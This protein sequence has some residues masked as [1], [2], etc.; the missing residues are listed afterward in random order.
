MMYTRSPG[1]V[2]VTGLVM[3]LAACSGGGGDPNSVKGTSGDFLVLRTSPPNN[4]K[5]F[6]NEPIQIDFS[7]EVDLSTAD[8]NTVSFA[9]FDLNG[10]ALNEQ[11]AGEFVVARSTGD[12][13]GLNRQLVFSPRFPTNNTFDNGGFRPGR[14][15][16]TQLVGGDARNRSVLRDTRGKALAQ[17]V[18]FRFTTADGTTP[19][20]LF[21][22]TRPGGPRKSS[23]AV[24]P[25]DNDGVSLNKLGLTAVEIRLGFDQPLNPSSENVPVR[26]QADPLKRD[27]TT[28]GRM[29]LEYDDPNGRNTWIPATVDLEKNT[30]QGS[31][32]VLRPVG[33]LPNNAEV[34][35]VVLSTLEDMSGESNVSDASYDPVFAR[36]GTRRDFE[37]QY[38]AIVERF[39]ST[40]AV[41]TSAAFLEP[42][43]VIRDGRIAASFAFEGGDSRLVYEP[44]AREVILN[45]DFTQI[46]PK[47]APPINVAG[48]VFTFKEVTIP[49]GVLVRGAGTK[50]M[51]WLVTGDFTVHGTLSVD[52]GLGARVDTLN[53]ANF[54][55]GGGVGTCGGG[56][57]GKGSP[58]SAGRSENGEPGF[59]PNQKPGGGGEGGKL[60]CTSSCNRGSAGGGGSLSTQGDPYYPLTGTA[61]PQVTG[62]GG[63][64]C[65]AKTLPGGVPGPR[66]FVDSRAENNFWGA[67]IDVF[68]QIRI[69]GEL[70]TPV[71]GAGGGG[72]G[73]RSTSCAIPGGS[74][75][76]SD[77]KGGGGGGGAGVLI[78]KALGRIIIGRNGQITANGGHGGGGEQAGGN[79]EGGGGGAGSG[80]TIVLMAGQGIDI[81]VHGSNPQNKAT[82][83]EA[84]FEFAIAADGG[85]GTQGRFSSPEILGKYPPGN[86]SWN[87]F[88]TGGFGGMGIIQLMVPP[89]DDADQT[90]NRLD[91]NV[92]FFF[93]NSVGVVEEV[94]PARKKA[95]LAWRGWPDAQGVLRDDNGVQINLGRN[96]GD[97]RPSPIM[98]PSPFGAI[99]RARS[100]WIDLGFAVREPVTGT[101][102]P[103]TPRVVV[104][105]AANA[106]KPDFFFDGTSR[107]LADQGYALYSSTGQVE[108]PV[109]HVGGQNRV[110]I[111][112]VSTQASFGG[113]PAYLVELTE[114]RL[115][116]IKD[117]YAQY[118]ARFLNDSGA[119][120]GDLRILGHT[121]RSLFLEASA[122]IPSGAASL[123][124]V[125]KFFEVITGGQ[126]GLGPTFEVGNTQVPVANVRIGFAFHTKPS[127]GFS[128][129]RYPNPTDPTT[130]GKLFEFDLN[131]VAFQKYLNGD[132]LASP[133]V[134]PRRPSFVQWDI[135]FNNRF[136]P[137]A[138]GNN[139]AQPLTADLPLPTID[140]L[141]IP[142]R[143]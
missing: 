96:E 35:V 124:I 28:R 131:S 140:Y 95:L 78:V 82:Y 132:P 123:Q 12:T 69:E 37:P 113:E 54:P 46:V 118:R 126:P 3:L 129:N 89:G 13:S 125:A 40:N 68:R 104:S 80:G 87:N 36:F 41:D 71:G 22:D 50:P 84:D 42:Q 116:S 14:V 134:P 93:I 97:M 56:N 107:Q 130:P 142:Y 27:L 135:L 98:L 9:V 34:R 53:S 60:S 81:F 92:R 30:L 77:N 102:G 7:N 133:P 65:T 52:G 63:K 21:K 137:T 79:N 74:G 8:L 111:R 103:N 88:P 11:P 110:A 121:D 18:S 127:E 43:A 114:A 33:V 26:V 75:F 99:S 19:A 119:T 48:G 91:D 62:E 83:G 73:D 141:V 90:G 86:T 25:S 109:V 20:Q 51:V 39:E 58:N 112:S 70:L 72:G 66:P 122:P 67:G 115:G 57:G 136:H 106:P 128:A 85:V 143:F 10:N 59:G 16:V 38:D 100:R 15:Y 55:T 47:G 23:F 138:A 139:S 105:S 44:N 2:S 64:G 120:L 6:L 17:P 117:R 108:F 94:T 32:V 4:G 101:P 1:F 45:T 29:F 5:L 61:W 31:T 49:E 76:I 24:T